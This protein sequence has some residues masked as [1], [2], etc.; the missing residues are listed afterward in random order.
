MHRQKFKV[1]LEDD[2]DVVVNPT[3]GR[4]TRIDAGIVERH[5]ELGAGKRLF[6][7]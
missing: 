6:H 7:V 3:G 2:G 4:I 5:F 1:I